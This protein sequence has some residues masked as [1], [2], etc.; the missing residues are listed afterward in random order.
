MLSPAHGAG[1]PGKVQSYG[2][3][4][5]R[6]ALLWRG[7]PAGRCGGMVK[8]SLAGSS[9]GVWMHDGLY[10]ARSCSGYWYL[11]VVVSV[12]YL[13]PIYTNSYPRIGINIFM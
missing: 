1:F 10:P 2:R 4:G 9:R 13:Y 8:P 12:S 5:K 3:V 6:F 7:R 11:L